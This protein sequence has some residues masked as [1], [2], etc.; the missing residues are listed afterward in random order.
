MKFLKNILLFLSAFVPMFVLILLK[1][2]IDIINSNLTF[3]VLN[4]LNLCTLVILILTGICG[5]YW[6]THEKEAGKEIYILSAQNITDKHFFGYFSLFVLFA[7]Q[8]DLSLISGYCTFVVIMFFIAVVYIKNA[9]FYINPLLNILGY[10]FYD[11][12][13]Q[14]REEGSEHNA[15][16]FSKG[17]LLPKKKY[18]ANIKNQNFTFIDTKK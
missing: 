12:T 7:L 2:I 1:L 4:T 10:N 8:L 14:L 6:S 18:V 9:L 16:I 13:Y 3:N 15:K 11:V 17:V 5:L